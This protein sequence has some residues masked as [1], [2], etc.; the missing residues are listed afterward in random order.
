MLVRNFW[1]SAWIASPGSLARRLDAL[2]EELALL[3]LPPR[4]SLP[5]PRQEPAPQTREPPDQQGAGETH[6]ET[7]GSVEGV[8]HAHVDP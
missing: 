5:P 4:R 3:I 8:V 2:H 7:H 6:D 1:V